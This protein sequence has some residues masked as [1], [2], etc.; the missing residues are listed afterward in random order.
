MLRALAELG[1]C[2]DAASLPEI[3]A[4]LAAGASAENISFGNTIK[5]S[6]DIK[7]AFALGVRLFAVDCLEEVEKVAQY[8]PAASVFCRL[9]CDGQGAQWPLSRKF[10]AEPNYVIE[11]LERA[12][13]YGLHAYGVSF[14]IGSQQVG[15]GAW[16]P[17]LEKVAKVFT[18]LEQKGISLQLVNLG[19]GFPIQYL[20]AVPTPAENAQVITAALEKY[21][22]GRKLDIILEPGRGMVADAGV[23]R[24]E[25]VLISR[26]TNDSTALRWVYLDVGRYNGLAEVAG[27]AIRYKI[28]TPYDGQAGLKLADC[29]LAGP[30]CDS[31]DVIYIKRPYPLPLD[32]K[33]GDVLFIL[34]AGAYTSSY[35]SVNFNGFTPIKT[36]VI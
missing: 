4:A 21:F 14:H 28:V 33:I 34:G 19:G 25:I 32:L 24:T 13:A 15:V 36:Y 6:K 2:F 3:K 8:A 23:M 7:A 12:H 29:F 9:L 35:A 30:T 11:V 10:G 22:P 16:E 26:R 1:S 20:E 31:E 18:S 17:A 27:E 5:K